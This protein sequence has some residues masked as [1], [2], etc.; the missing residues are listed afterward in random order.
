[1]RSVH[2][3]EHL[4]DRLITGH[5]GLL[6]KKRQHLFELLGNV[7][8]PPGVGTVLVLNVRPEFTQTPTSTDKSGQLVFDQGICCQPLSQALVFALIGSLASCPRHENVLDGFEFFEELLD[9]IH[10][11]PLL[12]GMTAPLPDDVDAFTPVIHTSPTTPRLWPTC[13]KAIA[14]SCH[15]G[16]LLSQMHILRVWRL[17]FAPSCSNIRARASSPVK[18]RA[19]NSEGWL[20]ASPCRGTN[21]QRKQIHL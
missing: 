4:T 9:R 16:A 6:L 8:P 5:C 7:M 20:T 11:S 1:M 18:V 21:S 13:R 14:V 12:A 15:L 17:P 10:G 19:T 2:L 3:V